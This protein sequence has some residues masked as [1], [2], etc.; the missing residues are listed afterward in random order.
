[1]VEIWLGIL[2]RKSLRGASFAN[3]KALCEHI[4]KFIEA[5]NQTAKPFVWKKREV[6]GA[7][8][9]NNMRNFCN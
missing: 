8:L 1:M 2:T 4:G 3:A 9:A 7:Q 6:T 5:Y